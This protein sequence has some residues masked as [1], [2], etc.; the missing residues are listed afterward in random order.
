MH[1][2][3]GPMHHLARDG[4]LVH[5]SSPV[6]GPHPR[7]PQSS[8]AAS[9]YLR[10][11]LRSHISAGTS[12]GC[13]GP[14]IFRMASTWQGTDISGTRVVHLVPGACHTLEASCHSSQLS[15]QGMPFTC[16][17]CLCCPFGRRRMRKQSIT[18]PHTADTAAWYLI[19][20][21]CPVNF[22]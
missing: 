14:Y 17:S 11:R 3:A 15:C 16:A 18:V 21:L 22:P 2:T 7:A 20:Q 9:L 5:V 6:L 12:G 10:S 4:R 19:W 1:R 13:R 8:P